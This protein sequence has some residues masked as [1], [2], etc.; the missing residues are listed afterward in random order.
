MAVAAVCLAVTV[1]VLG[2]LAVPAA[3]VSARLA[4]LAFP[5]QVGFDKYGIP[6]IRAAT[7]SDAFA[8]LGYVTARERLFQMDLLRR[9]AAGRLAEV[10][11]KEHL[12]SDRWHRIMGFESLA[13]EIIVRLPPEQKATVEAYSAG[14]NAAMRQARVWSLEFLVAGY[15]PEPWHPSDS[16][17][18]ILEMHAML[19]WSGDEERMLSVIEATLPETVVGF[20][21]PE[22]DCYNEHMAPLHPERCE[23]GA[24]VPRSEIYELLRERRFGSPNERVT[25]SRQPTGSNAWVVA[26]AKTKR[27]RA[28]LAND[29]HLPLGIPNIWYRAELNY[30]EVRLTG[31]TLPGVPLVVIGTNGNVAWGLTNIEGDFVDLVALEVDTSDPASYR[32]PEGETKFLHH[33]EM[34]LVKDAMSEPIEVRQTVWGPVLHEPLLGHPVAVH[35]VALDPN[36]TNL[37]LMDIDGMKT[38]ADAIPLFQHAGTPQLNVLLADKDGHIGWTIAGRVPRRVGLT[39]KFSRSWAHHGIGW[40]GYLSGLELP[41]VVDPTVGFLVNA[42]QRMLGRE[43]P[44]PLGHDYSSGYRANRILGQLR[45]MDNISEVDLFRLQLDTSAEF[46]RYYQRLALDLLRPADRISGITALEVKKFLESWDGKAEVDSLG[47]AL[48]LEFREAL[49]E[50]VLSPLFDRCRAADPTFR[51]SWATVDLVLQQIIDSHSLDLLPTQNNAQT[52]EGFLR[53]VLERSVARLLKSHHLENLHELHWGR[54]SH[55]RIQHPLSLAVPLLGHWFDMPAEPLAGCPQCVRFE[56]EEMGVTQRLVVSPGHEEDGILHMPGGQ[57]GHRWS[58][59][60]SDQQAAWLHG[61][62]LPLRPSLSL[63]G[64]AYLSP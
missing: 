45:I 52:W 13:Q 60:Y 49:I 14:V 40:E 62:P 38:V 28:I 8:A 5:V 9:S 4:G 43:Y 21:T 12:D 51:Y 37:D 46:Y 61:R 35:W 59:H 24:R 39:G 33:T 44:R 26:P 18:V 27:G 20:L 34:I 16:I 42:N 54:V 3:N 63:H 6:A 1:M 15:R 31:I 2:R 19:S 10:F 48:I 58:P 56:S 17:L 25:T 32:L 47:L 29:M 11:G 36:A 23:N 30:G 55:V 41:S 50:A 64:R 57:S 7:R 53:S 22:S